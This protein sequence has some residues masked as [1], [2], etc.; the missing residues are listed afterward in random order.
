[1]RIFKLATALFFITKA[2]AIDNTTTLVE[3]F[4]R[5]KCPS[6][7]DTLGQQQ[8]TLTLSQCH[9]AMNALQEVVTYCTNT[10]VSK[11]PW[12]HT[13]ISTNNFYEQIK[14]CRYFAADGCAFPKEC[15]ELS[16][17]CESL[18]NFLFYTPDEWKNWCYSAK[19]YVFLDVL[20][21][22]P[23]LVSSVMDLHAG[24]NLM[25][26]ELHK[27]PIWLTSYI[28][29]TSWQVMNYSMRYNALN[30]WAGTAYA[31]AEHLQI[32]CLRNAVAFYSLGTLFFLAGNMCKGRNRS[33]L[34]FGSALCVL[35]GTTTELTNVDPFR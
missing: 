35:A 8:C 25:N 22:A 28:L 14:N 30:E 29:R 31:D 19:A 26:T 3:V 12:C 13:A 18:K 4:E 21:A 7:V 17:K 16:L 2:F 20:F 6:M 15:N 23:L 5:M 32:N 27:E 34:L 11:I 1:M 10:P 33:A 24:N 9:K